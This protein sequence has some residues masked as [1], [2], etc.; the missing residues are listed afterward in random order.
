MSQNTSPPSDWVSRWCG[1]IKVGGRVLDVACGSGRH[2]RLLLEREYR[3]QAV[4]LDISG[5]A[6]LKGRPNFELLQADLENAPWPFGDD[7]F[8]GIVVTNYL[9][10]PLFSRLDRKSVV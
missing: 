4:D 5:L 8:D 9:Y 10:R 6:D 2:A 3:V 1:A 7:C